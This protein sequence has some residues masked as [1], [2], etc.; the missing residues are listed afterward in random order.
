M[1]QLLVRALVL[2]TVTTALACSDSSDQSVK[3]SANDVSIP[4]VRERVSTSRRYVN[5]RVS[6]T[7]VDRGSALVIDVVMNSGVEAS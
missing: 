1:R 6:P 5:L 2:L 7:L 4:G 3:G